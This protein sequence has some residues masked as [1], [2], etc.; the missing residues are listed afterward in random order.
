M[1]NHLCRAESQEMSHILGAI[2][3][4]L[5]QSKHLRSASFKCHLIQLASWHGPQHRA[6]ASHATFIL[7]MQ[8][9]HNPEEEKG[10]VCNRVRFSPLSSYLCFFSVISCHWDLSVVKLAPF[11]HDL[12]FLCCFG[13][14]FLLNIRLLN[15]KSP[16]FN[17]SVLM[18]ADD[19]RDDDDYD[20]CCW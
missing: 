7:C 14:Y 12:K 1:I 3:K 17:F 13:L 5:M 2:L 10:F 18:N 4:G 9:L 19:C 15:N 8:L 20:N 6:S 11:F 16:L